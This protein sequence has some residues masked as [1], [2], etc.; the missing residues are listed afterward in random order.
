M[1]SVTS[2]ELR[3]APLLFSIDLEEFYPATPGRDPRST[4][5]PQLTA[6]YLELLSRH[7]VK[8]TFFVVGDVARRYPGTIREI[9]AAGHELACHGDRHLTIDRLS[10][11]E[12]AADLRA[13]R[14]A[15]EVASGSPVRGFR[16][17]VLSLTEVTAWAFEVLA[18]E[19]F[20][21]SSSVLPAPN[22]LHGWPEFGQA[23]QRRSGVLEIPIA[24]ANL[25]R[26][27]LPLYSG[28]YFRVL[29]WA[30]IGRTLKR[31]P[32]D[33][34]LACYFHPYDIDHAQPWSMHAG[35][36]GNRL[37]NILLFLRRRS[38]LQR[39]DQLLRTYPLFARYC[40][41]VDV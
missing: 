5:L 18:R 13:N 21:Y 14:D 23:P 30:V 35:V 40:D 4:P 36:N 27:P 38:L 1:R 34:P 9:A 29:P 15:V 26:A 12:F 7:G 16:A 3:L 6:R 37:L 20:T 22:P 10:P 2:S 25:G 39:I 31:W 11:Q 32:P 24:V 28:T 41:F 17:P 33:L 8:G 19:G